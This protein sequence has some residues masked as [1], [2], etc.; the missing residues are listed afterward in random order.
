VKVIKGAVQYPNS[1]AFVE[2]FIGTIRRECLNHFLFFGRSHLESVTKI[3]L[4]YDHGSRPHQ[5]VGNELLVKPTAGRKSRSAA[6][7]DSET[8]SLAD[9][10]CEKKLGGLLKSYSYKAAWCRRGKSCSLNN[11]ISDALELRA[12]ALAWRLTRKIFE[13]YTTISSW[14]FH[15]IGS[16]LP[17]PT[18]SNIPHPV[19]T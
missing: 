15:F 18:P 19:A 17:N 2:R 10:R 11:P 4:D 6:R 13:Y 8:I 7:S 5:E 16:L 3:W 14:L 12:E 9:I 1:R